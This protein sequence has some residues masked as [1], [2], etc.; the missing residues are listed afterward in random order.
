MNLGVLSGFFN[1]VTA[2]DLTRLRQF[3]VPQWDHCFQVECSVF[4]PLVICGPF[5]NMMLTGMARTS[6]G[7]IITI[8]K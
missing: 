2:A 4:H 5:H 6:P 1:V 8:T 3:V 7:R